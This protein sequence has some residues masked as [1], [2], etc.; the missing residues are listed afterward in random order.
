M[1]RAHVD[2]DV[3]V[4]VDVSVGGSLPAHLCEHFHD[5]HDQAQ[6][7]SQQSILLTAYCCECIEN[8]SA[9]H[10]RASG[11][12]IKARSICGCRSTRTFSDV[13]RN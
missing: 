7:L 1:R 5:A 13:Q 12:A 4:D 6:R 2:V 9:L 3:D 11:N 10:R 8:R